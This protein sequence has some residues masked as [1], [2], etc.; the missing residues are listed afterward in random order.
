MGQG[1]KSGKIEV[2]KIMAHPVT[3]AIWAPNGQHVVLASMKTAYDLYC[4]SSLANS[5]FI[6]CSN[7]Q[8]CGQLVFVD[9]NDMSVMSKQEHPDLSSVE[10]DPTGRYVTSYVTLWSAKVFP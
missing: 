2:L 4:L 5:I 1:Q 6:L 10:W 9:T 7:S 3:T 8:N